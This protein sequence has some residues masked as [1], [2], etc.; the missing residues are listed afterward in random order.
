MNHSMSCDVLVS[1]FLKAEEFSYCTKLNDIFLSY[2]LEK[3]K[4]KTL[5]SYPGYVLE[6]DSVSIPSISSRLL[7]AVI[8]K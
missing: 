6:T 3:V 5:K 8:R 1:V 4:N 2:I 7:S